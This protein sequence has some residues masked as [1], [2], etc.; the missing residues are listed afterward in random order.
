MPDITRPTNLSPEQHAR[1]EALTV[2]CDVLKGRSR[3]PMSEPVAPE[4]TDLHS[5]ATYIVEGGNPWALAPAIE[6]EGMCTIPDCPCPNMP[7]VEVEVREEKGAH[8]TCVVK[9]DGVTV[10]SGSTDTG[11]ETIARLTEDIEQQRK[12]I[13]SL[14]KDNDD[15][16]DAYQRMC[17]RHFAVV[18]KVLEAERARTRLAVAVEEITH[19][20]A[21]TIADNSVREALDLVVERFKSAYPWASFESYDA[22]RRIVADLKP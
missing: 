2:A 18:K 20:K 4:P 14:R 6:S 10:F 16:H 17:T 7:D 15:V 19:E 12:L 13:E 9:R 11:A 1:A 21:Q 22:L 8:T 3:N 5:L